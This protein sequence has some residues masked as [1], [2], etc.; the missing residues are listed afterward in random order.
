MFKRTDGAN[1]SIHIVTALLE[2]GRRV[3]LKTVAVCLT[4]ACEIVETLFF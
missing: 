3:T 4:F 1:D 2:K